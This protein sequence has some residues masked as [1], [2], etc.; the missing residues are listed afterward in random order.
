MDVP[1]LSIVRERTE[2]GGAVLCFLSPLDAMLEVERAEQIGRQLQIMR[3]SDMDGSV[4]RDLDGLGL[5]ASFHVGWLASGSKV[6]VGENGVLGRYTR[7]IHEWAG[8]PEFFE[9]MPNSL[10]VFDDAYELAGLSAWHDTNRRL[11]Q[12]N[13]AQLREMA[14]KALDA[15]QIVKG[16][17]DDC[18]GLA[19][20][21]PEFMQWHFIKGEI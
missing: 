14:K 6:L 9:L 21:D 17:K 20:F 4:F 13:E 1:G 10:E 5:R 2:H 18:T 19:L 7:D 11:Q 12:G 15:V 8:D 3:A 16:Q